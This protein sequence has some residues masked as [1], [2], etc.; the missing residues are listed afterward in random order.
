MTDIEIIQKLRREKTAKYE[1]F[2][3]GNNDEN[4]KTKDII[5]SLVANGVLKTKVNNNT[6]EIMLKIGNEHKA[7]TIIQLHE[8]SEKLGVSRLKLRT[9][10]N[11]DDLPSRKQES[12]MEKEWYERMITEINIA[13]NEYGK[14]TILDDDGDIVLNEW[15]DNICLVSFQSHPCYPDKTKMG[16]IVER[17]HEFAAL[18][19]KGNPKPILRR[20]VK[21]LFRK[22]GSMLT[23]F[24]PKQFIFQHTH[25]DGI[26][27]QAFW[28]YERT[29]VLSEKEIAVHYDKDL[30][31][32]E[33]IMTNSNP[34]HSTFEDISDDD[35]QRIPYYILYKGRRIAWT[36]TQK[37]LDDFLRKYDENK[38]IGNM[39]PYRDHYTI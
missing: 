33:N 27:Y 16:I 11:K 23:V 37:Q 8:L 34:Y 17:N 13:E 5:I 26:I 36:D 4:S 2:L 18:V 35:S 21:E 28:G 1:S 39:K 19:D 14:F 7:N 31:Y 9:L 29:W 30:T 22:G 6:M 3:Y 15:F 12:Y 20:N 10:T 32:Y 38:K 24:S 25:D